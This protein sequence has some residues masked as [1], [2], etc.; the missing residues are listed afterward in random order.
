MCSSRRTAHGAHSGSPSG[1]D[2]SGPVPPIAALLL[3]IGLSQL[4]S[5]ERVLGVTAGHDS[6]VSFV[7]RV[8]DELEP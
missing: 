4:L 6:T 1:L 5:L 8:I 7:Q 2:P 3:V